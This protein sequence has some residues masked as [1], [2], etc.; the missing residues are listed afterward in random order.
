LLQ[1]IGGNSDG[2]ISDRKKLY[3]SGHCTRKNSLPRKQSL[4]QFFQGFGQRPE[5]DPQL[6]LLARVDPD[7][8]RGLRPDLICF[9]KKSVSRKI[10]DAVVGLPVVAPAVDLGFGLGENAI[11]EAT[12]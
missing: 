3:N 5:V 2:E 1:S 8:L 10:D 11:G 4:P 9:R 7:G 12:L 6:D